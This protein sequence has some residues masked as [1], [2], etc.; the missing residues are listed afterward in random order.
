MVLIVA[1]DAP[2]TDLRSL[3]DAARCQPN[4]LNYGSAGNGSPLH[5]AAELFRQS[6]QVQINHVPYTGGSAHTMDLTGGRLDM[7]LDDLVVT[8]P[9][10]APSAQDIV[11]AA[12][13]QITFLPEPITEDVLAEQLAAT[14][15]QV[16]VLQPHGQAD[17]HATEPDLDRFLA[18]IDILSLHCPLTG[19][20]HS[21][22]GHRELALLRRGSLR[23]NTA[24][25]PVVDEA[26]LLQ[27]LQSGHLAGA[28][29]DTFDAE[30]LP[31][32]HPLLTLPNV[33][34]TPHVAGVTRNAALQVA[35]ITARNIVDY[36]ATGTLPGHHLV[37]G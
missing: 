28:G 2:Y 22:I 14:G 29:L 7:I 16:L 12:A 23:I 31:A 36:L 37:T 21:L 27:A 4:A 15:A 6:A 33:L 30:P 9:H 5:L 18:Q 19:R 13:G 1:K 34:L 25:G 17:H 32:G 8:A 3:V 20:T 26:A 11:R 35:D 10:W 24:R